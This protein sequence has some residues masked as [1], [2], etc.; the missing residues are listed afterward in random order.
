MALTD[1]PRVDFLKQILFPF[2]VIVGLF[3]GVV[4]LVNA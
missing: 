2:L 1:P 4:L 3:V